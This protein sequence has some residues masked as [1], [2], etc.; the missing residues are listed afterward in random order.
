MRH[1]HKVGWTKLPLSSPQH[2]CSIFFQRVTLVFFCLFRKGVLVNFS[3]ILNSSYQDWTW[4]DRV[5]LN[6]FTLPS[7]H[8][9]WRPPQ[10]QNTTLIFAYGTLKRIFAYRTLE[11]W[12][13]YMYSHTFGEFW[14]HFVEFNMYSHTS[15]IAVEFI[16]AEW[17]HYAYLFVEKCTSWIALFFSASLGCNK[18][19]FFFFLIKMRCNERRSEEPWS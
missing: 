14:F 17:R 12:V 18:S 3:P 4:S 19:V 6:Y 9:Q 7:S 10:S 11:W 15:S 13:Q 1:L 5:I 2:C 8:N 16:V